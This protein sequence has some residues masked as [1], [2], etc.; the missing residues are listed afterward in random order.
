MSL[1]GINA[2]WASEIT[3]DK[4]DF[5]RLARTLDIIYETTLLRLVGRNFVIYCGSFFLGMRTICVKF[6]FFKHLPE[7]KTDNIASV[8]SCPTIC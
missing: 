5:I 1:S 8:T 2:L 3:L 4:M 6:I 7:C